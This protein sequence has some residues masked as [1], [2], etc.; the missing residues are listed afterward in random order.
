MKSLTL[1]LLLSFF[2]SQAI[3]GF[4]KGNGGNI[5]FC[6][7]G[8]NIVLDFYELGELHKLTPSRDI[9]DPA[10]FD[11]SSK[12]LSKLSSQMGNDLTKVLASINDRIRYIGSTFESVNDAYVV[13]IPDD[14]ELAQTAVQL[15]GRILIQASLYA[16]LSPTQ[17]KI[18]LL[19][20]AIYA[21]MLE[22]RKLDDSRPVRALVSLLLSDEYLTMTSF[23]IKKFLDDNKVYIY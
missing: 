16:S 11:I 9:D 19:H 15:N 14:C 5:L 4:T 23:D 22:K 7:S 18:L 2:S 8:K 3:A 10:L 6:Q 20:E 17:K 12:R 1:L 21:V 13:I